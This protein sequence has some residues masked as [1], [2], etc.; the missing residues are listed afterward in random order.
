MAPALATTGA[1]LLV[2]SAVTIAVLTVWGRV[3][4][5]RR[6]PSFRCRLGPAISRRGRRARWR[7]RRTRATWVGD[8]LMVRSGPLRL[9]LTPLPVGVLREVTVEALERGEVRGLGRR[10]AA[11][12]FT[13]RG[14]G[15]VEIAVAAQDVDSLVGPFLTATL[16]GL[17]EARREP[18]G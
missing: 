4:D 17:P 7:L 11:L 10:P 5:A 16:A 2:G 9:W 3:R 6:L 8:V 12:R 14:G 18:G 1:G 15:E 13:L